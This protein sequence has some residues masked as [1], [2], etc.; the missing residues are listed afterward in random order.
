VEAAAGRTDEAL[1]A[2]EKLLRGNPHW[3][4]N[5]E[6]AEELKGLVERPEAKAILDRAR[7]AAKKDA[8]KE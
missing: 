7:Q 8:K 2:I 4:V 3:T 1:A 5:V 6:K